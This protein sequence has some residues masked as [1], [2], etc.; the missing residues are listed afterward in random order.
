MGE[1]VFLDVTKI[2]FDALE[3]EDLTNQREDLIITALNAGAIK[4]L[5]EGNL[6]LRS[7]RLSP[8][9]FNSDALHMAHEVSEFATAM[10]D[11]L[12]ESGIYP[13]VLYGEPYK[14]TM[15]VSDYLCIIADMMDRPLGR[16]SR[17]KEEK[18]HGEGGTALG[19]TLHLQDVLILD[20]VITTKAAK[21]SAF[22][23]VVANKGEVI[24]FCILFDRLETSSDTSD[25]SALAELQEEK[26]VP[27]YALTD[28]S[29]LLNV[30]NMAAEHRLCEDAVTHDN[31]LRVIM[32]ING[33]QELYGIKA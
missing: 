10:G 31:L 13:D 17:R 2:N 33:Y 16:A 29:D 26:D 25:K 11:L 14:G 23:H 32:R 22:N 28:L 24:G 8:Y 30:L 1:N 5:V 6:V 7:G 27:C 15:L 3:E 18:D 20:D 21:I 9:F 4:L 12:R 19:A